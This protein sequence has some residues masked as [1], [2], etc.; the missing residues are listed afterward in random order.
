MLQLPSVF[1]R[2]DLPG[3]GLTAH[4]LA[5][6]LAR[7]DV[8]QPIR[9]VYVDAA[10]ADDLA[11]RAA[12]LALVL[13]PGAA[14]ARSAAAW[15]HG[16]DC[17]PPGGLAVP[18]P[19]DVVVPTGRQPC[20]H[21]AVVGH[22]DR[23]PDR[24][25]IEIDGIPV[26]SRERTVL[27]LTRFLPVF[28]GLAAADAFAHR[29]G[30]DPAALLP[31]LD[32]WRGQRHVRRARWVLELCEPLTESFGESWTR[33]RLVE[34]GFPRPEPQ[35]W[36]HDERGVALYRLD[37]GWREQKV[38]IEYDGEEYHSEDDVAG[39]VARREILERRYG[40]HVVGVRKGEV[41]GR[42]LD[43]ERGVG[44]LLGLEPQI[45]VRGW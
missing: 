20:S 44:E 4:Q 22:V 19:L 39:D 10:L 36:V 12:A 41:L 9:G 38:A 34:A 7:G 27:D 11:T 30:I 3:L 26:T 15:L 23:L 32:E 14:L 18:L 13:P 1:R 33:L 29:F 35:I 16:V 43:L 17:R 25:V 24:D 31:R 28:M 21:A 8:V 5:P 40:W 45:R 37:M 42:R 2:H 6:L